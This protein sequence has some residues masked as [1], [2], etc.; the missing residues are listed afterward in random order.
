MKKLEGLIDLKEEYQS[1]LNFINKKWD[2]VP[3]FESLI[4]ESWKYGLSVF[5]DT[6]NH[7]NIVEEVATLFEEISSDIEKYLSVEKNDENKKNLLRN[8]FEEFKISNKDLILKIIKPIPETEYRNINIKVKELVN[9]NED[10]KN[11]KPFGWDA[12]VIEHSKNSD[13]YRMMDVYRFKEEKTDIK[14][15]KGT[16]LTVFNRPFVRNISLANVVYDELEQGNI[17][18]VVLLEVVLLHA[19]ECI[20]YNNSETLKKEIEKERNS[21]NE[22]KEKI[23]N[24]EKIK[25]PFKKHKI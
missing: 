8:F 21:F 20:K 9:S 22:L 19:G 7:E 5:Q 25:K 14:L 16:N 3:G 15:F 13:S 17:R 6:Y 2:L 11:I 24:E 4:E 12:A 10:F 18:P 1:V 23:Y